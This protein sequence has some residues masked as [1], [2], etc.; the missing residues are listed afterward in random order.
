MGVIGKTC[1]YWYMSLLTLTTV[2]D[3]LSQNLCNSYILSRRTQRFLSELL[4]T[5]YSVIIVLQHYVGIIGLCSSWSNSNWSKFVYSTITQ[6]YRWIAAISGKNQETITLR[7]F[8]QYKQMN[9]LRY[10]LQLLSAFLSILPF[11]W[12]QKHSSDN[13]IAKPNITHF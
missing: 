13:A 11:I 4:Y 10:I 12:F 7:S 6:I 8:R 3:V 9:E 5:S 2:L 1:I